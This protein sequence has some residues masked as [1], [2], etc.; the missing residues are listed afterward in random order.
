M[1]LSVEVT[2]K[3]FARVLHFHERYGLNYVDYQRLTQPNYAPNA[4]GMPSCFQLSQTTERA[5]PLTKPLQLWMYGLGYRNIPCWRNTTDEGTAFFNRSGIKSG[6]ADYIQGINLDADPIKLQPVIGTGATVRV[7]GNK[8][9]RGGKDCYPI[10][11]LNANDPDTLQ[12]TLKDAWWLV[13]AATVS[14]IEPRPFGQVN[15]FPK[16]EDYEVPI[17]LL[18]NNTN[19]LYI[20]AGWLSFLD[21]PVTQPV[22]PYYNSFVDEAEWKRKTNRGINE[23]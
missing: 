18:G 8:V 11:C 13:F 21:A 22:Y 9:R 16:N 10:E 4:H 19:V 20:E 1:K 12:R 2:H 23:N 15:P 17:P 14:T 7:V 6:G 5:V 3:V